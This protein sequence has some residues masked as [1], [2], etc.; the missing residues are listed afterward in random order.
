MILKIKGF[1]AFEKGRS[2]FEAQNINNKPFL[3]GQKEKKE[4]KNEYILVCR[5]KREE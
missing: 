1:K 5:A 4:R 2:L 3:R